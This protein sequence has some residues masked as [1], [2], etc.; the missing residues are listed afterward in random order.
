MNNGDE[1]ADNDGAVGEESEGDERVTSS[2]TFPNSE[3]DDRNSSANEECDTVS[4]R[5]VRAFAVCD[6]DGDEDHSEPC[7]EE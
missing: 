2:E 4:I 5:P 7:Y 6:S 3:S 1:E